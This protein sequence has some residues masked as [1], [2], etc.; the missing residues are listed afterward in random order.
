MLFRSDPI[1]ANVKGFQYAG[2]ELIKALAANKRLTDNVDAGDK[3]NDD[4]G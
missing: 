4:H 2:S 3:G 1:Y